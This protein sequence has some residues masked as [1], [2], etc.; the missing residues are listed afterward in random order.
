MA[1]FVAKSGELN[2]YGTELENKADEFLKLTTNMKKIVQD[3]EAGWEGTDAANFKANA[4]AY[5]NNLSYIEGIIR[6]YG[7]E[8]KKKAAK[9][10][11]ICADFYSI[12]NR[13]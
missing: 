2:S 4:T 5:L 3:L 7:N 10:D 11:N 9:Y 1:N 13:Q 6:Y 12:L 8:I